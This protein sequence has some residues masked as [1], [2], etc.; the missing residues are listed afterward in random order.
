M[1]NASM[2]TSTRS[3]LRI[4]LRALFIIIAVLA[5]SLAYL[6]KRANDQ[7][8]AVQRVLQ[9]GGSVGYDF[10][11]DKSGNRLQNP[12][13]PTWSLLRNL[14]GVEYFANVVRIGLDKAA[15]TEADLRCIG[16]LRHVRTL[17]LN[18]TGVTD[19]GLSHLRNLR[20]LRILGLAETRITDAGLHHLRNLYKL[21]TLILEG[22]DI[23][24]DGLTY[25]GMLAQLENLN[26][27]E[28]SITGQDV[29]HLTRLKNLR[30]LGLRETPIDDSALPHLEAMTS[31]SEL[32]LDGSKI[33]GNG[34]RRLRESF[35]GEGLSCD[36]IDLTKS[37]ID[38][39]ERG[40]QTWVNLV[41]RIRG[42][43]EEDL[44]KYID[45]SNTHVSDEQLRLLEGLS[46]VDLIDLRG[47]PVT[48]EGCEQLK[49][50]LPDVCLLR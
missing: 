37:S 47:T 12:V 27:G 8:V 50:V 40:R 11:F 34:L 15:I 41:S 31:L 33:S 1:S 46:H 3:Y 25:V 18:H 45:L 49:K 29:E 36:M 44:L 5:V 10:E 24:G 21:D 32:W 20:E 19:S 48:D 39:S 35:A 6:S 30:W 38:N 13:P 28:T 4:S 26:L 17:S 23:R 42:L 7:R 14:I 2:A 43:D 16:R 9:L 22:T